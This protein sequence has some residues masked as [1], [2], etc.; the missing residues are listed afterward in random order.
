M[1]RKQYIWIG[2]ILF[3]L[4]VLLGP[5][6]AFPKLQMKLDQEVN[7]LESYQA[8]PTKSLNW[9]GRNAYLSVPEG[10]DTALIVN[11]MN[12]MKAVRG[13]RGVALSYGTEFD[14]MWEVAEPMSETTST[15]ETE[16]PTEAQATTAEVT[17]EAD[18]CEGINKL[19]N[20]IML[21]KTMP[22]NM[23]HIIMIKI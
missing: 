4:L 20:N 12:D 1:K 7:G 6:V 13:V 23:S 2:V 8:I 11:A 18:F 21:T 14:E 22:D 9:Q 3:L 19:T 16:P 10:M 17:T 5:L 15:P